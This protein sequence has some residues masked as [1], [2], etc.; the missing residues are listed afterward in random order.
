[1]CNISID[2][3]KHGKRYVPDQMISQFKQCM[4]RIGY[5]D[6]ME[7]LEQRSVESNGVLGHLYRQVKDQEQEALVQ[8]IQQDYIKSI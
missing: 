5:P 8:F 1:M 2:F 4:N 6:F 3:G 7:K